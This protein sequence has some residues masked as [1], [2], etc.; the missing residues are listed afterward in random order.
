MDS[1]WREQHSRDLATARAAIWWTPNNGSPRKRPSWKRNTSSPDPVSTE[2]KPS[3]DILSMFAWQDLAVLDFGCGVGRNLEWLIDYGKCRRL[4]GMDFPEML[5]LAP[6]NLGD[7]VGCV[8][9][10]RHD[11]RDEIYPRS[12]DRI[13]CSLVLQHIPEAQLRDILPWFAEI[14]ASSGCLVLYGRECGDPPACEPVIP[15]VADYLQR[16]I[17]FPV[18]SPDQYPHSVSVWNLK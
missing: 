15:V 7:R 18:G 11:S 8:E 2:W 10:V 9:L 12:I 17:S 5:R 1:E 16:V 3:A 13:L 6:Q 14:L 4:I